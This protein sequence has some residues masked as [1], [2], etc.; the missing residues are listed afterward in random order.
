M[1]AEPRTKLKFVD[2]PEFKVRKHRKELDDMALPAIPPALHYEPGQGRSSSAVTYVMTREE[3][4]GRFL[5]LNW[6][7]RQHNTAIKDEEKAAHFVKQITHLVEYL[8]R[9]NLPLVYSQV[10]RNLARYQKLDWNE[11]VSEAQLSLI[12]A[13]NGYNCQFGIKFSTYACRIILNALNSANQKAAKRQSRVHDAL[14]P[15]HY[16]ESEDIAQEVNQDVEL[17]DAMNHVLSENAADLSDVE[18]TVVQRR[19]G[20]GDQEAQT[21]EEI[22]ND[23]GVSKERVRQIQNKALGKLKKAMTVYA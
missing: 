21:L 9:T 8:V 6:L 7:K 12:R 17:I 13:V 23:I 14:V 11:S 1:A 10:A 22:G 5:Q 4:R 15:E 2:A 3:E 19:Y 18:K 16:G 20:L